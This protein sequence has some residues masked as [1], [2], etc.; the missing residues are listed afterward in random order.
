MRANILVLA[1]ETPGDDFFYQRWENAGHVTTDA[2]EATVLVVDQRIEVTPG[3]LKEYPNVKYVVSATTGHTHLKFDQEELGIRIVSLRGETE[4]L[5]SVRSVSEFVFRMMLTLARPL[6]DYGFTLNNKT[7]GIVGLGRIGKHVLFLGA[8]FGMRCLHF[9][10]KD[11][12]SRLEQIFMESD[13]VTIHLSENESTFKLISS[14]LIR[15]MKPTAYFINTAR[16][17]V[18]DEEALAKALMENKIAGAALDTVEDSNRFYYFPHVF[19][20]PHVAGS[21]LEDRIKTDNFIVRKLL[22]VMTL[23][24]DIQL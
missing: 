4:F 20:T 11:P 2:R 8:A 14:D 3:F 9:D 22:R 17:S 24:Q 7:L 1:R 18:I 16:A 13:F 19:I 10:L 21:T 15:L 6:H 5:S 12:Y 23:S